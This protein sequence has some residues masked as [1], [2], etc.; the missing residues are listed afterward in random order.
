MIVFT[1]SMAAAQFSS[2]HY[3]KQGEGCVRT[4][5][6]PGLECKWDP[7]PLKLFRTCKPA[8]VKII[9]AD[10]F[11]RNQQAAA[12]NLAKEGDSCVLKQC[13]PGLSCG[14]SA[15]PLKGFRICKVTATPAT[16][17]SNTISNLAKEGESCALRACGENL[18]CKTSPTS[19]F[20]LFKVC[21]AKFASEG[22]SCLLKQCAEGYKCE[23]SP[24]P[25]KSFR[26]CNKVSAIESIFG[27][28]NPLDALNLSNLL[29]GG[30]I[31]SIFCKGII[32]FI[33][34]FIIGFAAGFLYSP[35]PDPR[36]SAIIGVAGG[37]VGIIL[38]QF[39]LAYWWIIL[40]IGLAVFYLKYKKK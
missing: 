33:L 17:A 23:W 38:G 18:E 32:G 15:N 19:P 27:T 40:L 8:P 31:T 9:P 1:S 37:V 20:K 10:Q 24:N 16:G 14:F 21:E 4:T 7:N 29:C 26:Q 25:L 13:G 3:A 11:L 35:L 12:T 5:C 6:G 39:L 28:K 22:Q 30:G 2:S 36:I 34:P